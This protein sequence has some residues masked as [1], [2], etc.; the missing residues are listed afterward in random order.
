MG[1]RAS[2]D[3]VLKRIASHRRESNPEHLT[4]QPVESDEIIK[5]IK[6]ISY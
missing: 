4:V 2:L 6:G 1:P 5:I 3:I